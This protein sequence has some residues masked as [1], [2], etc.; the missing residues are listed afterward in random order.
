MKDVHINWRHVK[1]QQ[2]SPWP[3]LVIERWLWHSVASGQLKLALFA[4]R[5]SKKPTSI[6]VR[7]WVWRQPLPFAAHRRLLSRGECGRHHGSHRQRKPLRLSLPR[8]CSGFSRCSSLCANLQ[9]FLLKSDV[10]FWAVGKD[11]LITCLLVT[12]AAL[13]GFKQLIEQLINCLKRFAFNAALDRS[14]VSSFHVLFWW[15]HLINC[16]RMLCQFDSLIDQLWNNCAI[17][18]TIAINY[19]SSS[20][21]IKMV[22]PLLKIIQLNIS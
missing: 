12:F 1:T 20:G 17:N 15:E 4:Y 9:W 18:Y 8:K 19:N 7:L 3:L 13:F 22:I 16:F 2:T 11:Y 10:W 21:D 14:Q 5:A 6:A